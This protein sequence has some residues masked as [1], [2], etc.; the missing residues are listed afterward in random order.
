MN[1][2]REWEAHVDFV[3]ATQKKGE[4]YILA[5]KKFFRWLFHNPFWKEKNA[6]FL[7]YKKEDEFISE[8][9]FYPVPWRYFGKKI[10]GQFFINLMSREEYRGKGVG[11]MLWKRAQEGASL[12]MA[13]GYNQQAM[14][15]VRGFGWREMP[16]LRRFVAFLN[17]NACS[18]L[19]EKKLSL[20]DVWK[21]AIFK[22]GEYR[23]ERIQRF[24]GEYEK[25][26]KSVSKRYSLTVDRSAKYMN[27]RY[28]EHPL[29]RYDVFCLKKGA[30]IRACVVI[31]IEKVPGFI[32]GRIVDF[33]AFPDGEAEAFA[34]A[35]E[36]CKNKK[37]DLVDMFFS[38]D[39]HARAFQK[40][41]FHE[42]I[43]K[44]HSLVPK[45]FNPIDR[46]K[47]TINF[48][49]FFR[50]PKQ[51]SKRAQNMRNWYLTK[52][53]SDQDRPN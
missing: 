44:P 14:P 2:M 42:A 35:A 19:I 52:G 25:F 6:S 41:G 16:V 28:A 36:F 46:K 53:D 22:K 20:S 43:K 13:L 23:W 34:R 39:V 18:R 7:R 27:W 5:D 26:W 51:N 45:L 17:K 3:A 4:K 37:A 10:Q 21:P 48:T 32:L 50:D 38:G 29:F 9:G 30:D 15:L 33:I 49:Y 12:S 47:M 1:D 24:G 31:R 8:I 40:A 11:A